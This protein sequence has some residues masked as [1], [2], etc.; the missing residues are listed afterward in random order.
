M[1]DGNILYGQQYD[2]Q[3]DI[4]LPFTEQVQNCTPEGSVEALNDAR[5]EVTPI[6]ANASRVRV[7]TAPTQEQMDTLAVTLFDNVSF[8]LPDTLQSVKAYYTAAHGNGT[9][10]E[11]GDGQSTGTT[12]SLSI[13]LSASSQGSASIAGDVFI[14]ILPTSNWAVDVPASTYLFYIADTSTR[15]QILTK[16]GTLAGATVNEWPKFKPEARTLFLISQQVDLSARASLSQ[17]ASITDGGSQSAQSEGTAVSKSVGVTLRTLTIP[18]TIHGAITIVNSGGTT[19]DVTASATVTVTRTG[20]GWLTSGYWPA[21][22]VTTTPDPLEATAAATVLSEA[23]NAS[24]P[25]TSGLTAIPTSGK[26]ARL[27]IQ[28]WRLG[29]FQVRAEVVDFSFFA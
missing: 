22:S 6:D 16:V 29:Y 1:S 11:T 2:E 8:Q 27:Q 5:T 25:A 19:E 23:F 15:A 10:E 12:G 21:R 3:T 26:Y 4:V 14:K 28:P 7:F 13:N 20:A 17:S 24:I 18:P 9:A